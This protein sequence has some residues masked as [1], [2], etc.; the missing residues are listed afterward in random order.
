MPYWK[1]KK[2]SSSVRPPTRDD[3]SLSTLVL[4]TAGQRQWALSLNLRTL[5]LHCLSLFPLPGGLAGWS[6]FV[7]DA[8]CQGLQ[9]QTRYCKHEN[10]LW[11][12]RTLRP[13][14]PLVPSHF[15]CVRLFAT[16]WIIACQAPLSM[17]FSRQE[18]WSGLPCPPPRAL[19]D[20][21]IKLASPAPRALQEDFLSIQPP[22][23]PSLSLA[24]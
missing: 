9:Y 10:R 15:S 20:P 19:P 14:L 1:Q 16:L 5:E 24:A 13:G 18:Y 4:D 17:G 3:P 22:G 2:D 6:T 23:K 21:G 11:M 12:D 8:V 7:W